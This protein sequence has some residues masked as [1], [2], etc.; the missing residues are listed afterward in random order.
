MAFVVMP[1][2]ADLVI[3]E[4]NAEADADSRGCFRSTRHAG[5]AKRHDACNHQ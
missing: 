5:S 2:R 3:M 1:D 4:V